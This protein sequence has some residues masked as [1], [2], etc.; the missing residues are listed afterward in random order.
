MHKPNYFSTPLRSLVEA[1]GWRTND[2][3]EIEL[4]DAATNPNHSP[5]EPHPEYDRVS[6]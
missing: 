3:G 2:R 4:G 6:Q 1:T 5:W